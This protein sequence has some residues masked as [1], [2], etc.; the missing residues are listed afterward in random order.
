MHATNATFADP[1]LSLVAGP[2][3]AEEPGQGVQTIGGYLREVAAKYGQREALVMRKGAFRLSW[4]YDELLARS[5]DVAR[6]LMASGVG[7]GER[8]ALLMTNRPEFLSSL[9]GIALAGGVPVALSTF[10]TRQELEYLVQASEASILLFE[11]HVLKK[12]FWQMLGDLEPE[13]GSAPPGRLVSPRFPYLRHLVSLGG[14]PGEAEPLEAKA[15][16]AVETWASFIARGEGIAKEAVL[17]RADAVHPADPGGIFF[18]SGTTSLPKGIVHSQRAFAIQW[19]RWPR[20]FAMHEPVRAWTGNGFFWSGNVSM[21]VGAA[22][23][24]GGAVILQRVFDADDALFLAE[25]EN[26]TFLNGRPHQW[27]RLAASPHWAG[28]DLS[29]LKYVT[30][31]ELIW[32]HPTVN[33]DWDVPMS[34]GCTETMTICTSFVADD[35]S[36]RVE[37][38]FGSPLP[39]NILKIVEPISGRIVP[40]GQVGEMCIKGPTLMSGYLGKAPEECLDA[41]GFFCTGDGGRVDEAGRFYWEGRLTD[42]IKTGGANVS[43]VEVDDVIARIPGVKRTQTVGVPDDLLGEM[44][45]ACIVPVD[46]ADVPEADVIARCKAELASFKVPRHVLFFTDADYAITGS[47]KVK[48]SE[49]RELAVRR[50]QDDT[51][52]AV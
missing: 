35:D 32:Q 29:S 40:V 25:H 10:S 8:V 39:G 24:T 31:G 36:E 14:I 22:L 47:E 52:P 43:P 49:V 38:T 5:L 37:G 4:S 12:D 19:W 42:M 27:A 28:A 11:Q 26:V 20:L 15:G 30:R 51:A 41:E 3:L 18:S 13:I 33:T 34:F 48:S 9:F 7:K 16:G 46:G 50:L 2:P 44:V 6:A 21:V 45:V 1:A 23:S 17:A